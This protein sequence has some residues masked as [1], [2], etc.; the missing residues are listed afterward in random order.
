[1]GFAQF[2]EVYAYGF[3]GRESIG[4]SPVR[5][6]IETLLEVTLDANAPVN[7]RPK[8]PRPRALTTDRSRIFR[9]M[10][11]DMPVYTSLFLQPLSLLKIDDL[12]N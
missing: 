8:P 3:R 9:R 10:A 4:V 5:K 2:T 7:A 1:M 6:F 12:G 11:V